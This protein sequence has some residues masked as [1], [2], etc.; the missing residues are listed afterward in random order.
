VKG[1]TLRNPP[2]IEAIFEMKWQLQES[3]PGLTHDPHYDLLIGRLYD[4]LERYYPF[5]QQL[6]AASI[7]AEMLAGVVQHRFRTSQ[8]KWPVFQVGPGVLTV[9]DT[10]EYTWDDFRARILEAVNTLFDVYPGPLTINNLVL[11]YVNA[12]EFEFDNENV[13][14]FLRHQLKTDISL[15]PMLFEE[16]GVQKSPVSLDCRFTLKCNQPESTINLRFARGNK[17]NLDALFWETFVATSLDHIPELPSELEKW[18]QDSHNVL[19]DWFFKLVEGDLLRSF[20]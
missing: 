19:E 9:N 1:E 10:Q 6:P 14:E 2:L 3:A 12:V 17:Q 13:F 16:S 4:R 7:P 15:H 8:D 11:R 18:L 20:E 5:H